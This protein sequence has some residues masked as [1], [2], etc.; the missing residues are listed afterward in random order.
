[1][2]PLCLSGDHCALEDL[3]GGQNPLNVNNVYMLL[4]DYY[5][6]FDGAL[7]GKYLD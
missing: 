6:V 1:M 3:A 2:V 7:L 4:L 5:Y